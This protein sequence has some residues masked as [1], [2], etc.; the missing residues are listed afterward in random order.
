MDNSHEFR[1]VIT[2][3]CNYRCFFCHNEGFVEEYTPL[4]LSPSDYEFVTHI[5]KKYWGWDTVTITGGEPLISPIFRETCQ[6]IKKNNIR[7]T[8]V[9]NA[10]LISNPKK[11]LSLCD[12]IN[13]SLHSVT[14]ELY[15]R[16]TGTSYPVNHVIDTITSIRSQLPSAIIHIN[17]TIIRGFNDDIAEIEKILWLADRV[18]AE[19]KFIDLA[20]TNKSLVVTASEIQ[21]IL[22]EAQFKKYDENNWQIFLKRGDTKTTITRC[23][24][25]SEYAGKEK[26][27]LFLN[28]DG[29]LSTGV[30]NELTVSVL[31]EIHSRKEME[32]VEKVEWFFPLAKRNPEKSVV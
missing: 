18:D 11:I 12:Q 4:L 29:V 17:C 6:R 28:P 3:F 2:P 23:G 22:E 24:F 20:S 26:R 7:I 13:I 32:F 9:T 16:I 19:A 27:N 10:S 8:V 1:I 21:S 31:R 14:P 15:R 5:G 25:S 30:A